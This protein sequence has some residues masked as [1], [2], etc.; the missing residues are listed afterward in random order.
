MIF[1][2]LN[3]VLQTNTFQGIVVTNGFQSYALFIYECGKLQWSGN[4][5]IGFKANS[6]LSRI[7]RLSGS[8]ASFVACEN[9]PGSVWSNLVYQLRKL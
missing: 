5:A 1:T 8:N 4:G 2:I 6:R 7:H 9:S 3:L